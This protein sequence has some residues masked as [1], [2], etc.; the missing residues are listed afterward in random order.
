[1]KNLIIYQSNTLLFAYTHKALNTIRVGSCGNM[2]SS[3]AAA[4]AAAAFK[5]NSFKIII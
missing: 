4:A 3:V 1:M 5:T 2:F